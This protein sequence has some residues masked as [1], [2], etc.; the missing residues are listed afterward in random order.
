MTR[1]R[2]FDLALVIA[3]VAL[4][5]PAAPAQPPAPPELAAAA[6]CP[7]PTEEAGGPSTADSRAIA[8]DIVP[9]LTGTATRP[10]TI[11][12]R[13][14][15]RYVAGV[16]VAVIRGGKLAWARGWGLRDTGTCQPVTPGTAFQAASISK[17][18][19]AVLAMRLVEQGRLALDAAINRSLV[20]WHLPPDNRFPPGFVTLRQL[21]DH[22]AGISVAG[23]SGYPPGT[24]LPNLVDILD[25]TPPANNSAVRIE[26][27][28][29]GA[30]HYSGGGY[31]IVQAAIE[32]V[33]RKPFAE[34][35]SR[36]ILGPLGM[37]RS[38]FAQ[39]AS[40][41]TLTNAATG[42]FAARP[43]AT[44]FYVYPELAA[45]G[46]WTTPTDLG[47]FLIDLRAALDGESGHLVSPQSAS[48]MLKPRTGK[49]GLGFAFYGSGQDKAFGDIGGNWGYLSQMLI[50]PKTGDGIVVMTNG[51]QG[52]ALAAEIIRAAADHYGWAD[53]RSHPLM[54]AVEKGPLRLHGTM[55]SMPASLEPDGQ[56]VWAADVVLAPGTYDLKIE[57]DDGVVSLGSDHH[58]PV[59]APA[60]DI[61]L[62]TD[63]GD[64]HVK[65]GTAGTYRVS[66][67]ADATGVASVSVTPH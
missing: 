9:A 14:R 38:S 48:A 34:L 44:K 63:S 41:T 19:A 7:A 61:M 30:P 62:S 18:F 56:G 4:L 54:E 15:T 52:L 12:E 60:R 16:S 1:L 49:G 40:P 67:H 55:S 32:D 17:G 25:G 65:I 64:L 37:T 31:V 10:I 29:G 43:F 45:A 21:L 35:A 20:R 28:P 24:P 53:F 6:D 36:E 23:F 26:A 66:F 50:N 51:E 5:A 27:K 3:A 58:N 22:T 39:P 59:V 11:L 8:A 42:H 13:M 2:V 57:S 33:T 46:L 47:R